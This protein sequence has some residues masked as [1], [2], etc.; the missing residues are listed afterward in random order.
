MSVITKAIGNLPFRRTENGENIL[1]TQKIVGISEV[2]IT[3]GGY[4]AV[5]V[6]SGVACKAVLAKTRDAEN[7]LLSNVS[8]GTTYMTITSPLSVDIVGRAGETLFYAK[9]TTN[10]TLE[11]IFLD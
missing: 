10:G 8:A 3:T 7:W 1:G 9:A 2:A 11:V 5:N 4:V 6:P